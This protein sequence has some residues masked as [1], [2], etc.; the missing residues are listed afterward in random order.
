MAVAMRNHILLFRV[1]VIS[2]LIL[3][4]PTIV[5]ICTGNSYF[6][7]FLIMPLMFLVFSFAVFLFAKY[8]EKIFLS[9]EI[10][11]HVFEIRNNCLFKNGKEVKLTQSIIIYQY[12]EFLYM[13]TS[14]SMFTIKNTDYIEGNR[15][16]LIAWAKNNGIKVL[17]GY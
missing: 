7:A 16:E 1:F 12:N 3:L 11:D 15:E 6:W 5:F 8:D 10:K 13:E 2:S 14:H 4:V 17:Y 9:N